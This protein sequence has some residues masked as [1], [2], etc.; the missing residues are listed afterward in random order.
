MEYSLVCSLVSSI[1]LEKPSKN[2]RL[3]QREPS[4]RFCASR[5]ADFETSQLLLGGPNFILDSTF[6]P[7]IH[8]QRKYSFGTD[9]W[10]FIRHTT[11]EGKGFGN[12]DRGSWEERGGMEDVMDEQKVDDDDDKVGRQE[13]GEKE[14]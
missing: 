14:C 4:C 9:C 13:E 11:G 7:F 5:G 12:G 1:R 3:S 2:S 10:R 8:A 6:S